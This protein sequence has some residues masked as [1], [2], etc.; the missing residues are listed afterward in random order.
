MKNE[1]DSKRCPFCK[2]SIHVEAIKCHHCGEWLEK[3][4][5]AQFEPNKQTSLRV[6]SSQSPDC[7]SATQLDAAS[8]QPPPSPFRPKRRVK[9]SSLIL[10]LVGLFFVWHI[11]AAIENGASGLKEMIV[12]ALI[13]CTTPG[14]IFILGSLALW[15]WVVK[16][17]EKCESLN[18]QS[19]PDGKDG[20]Q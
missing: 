6:E 8:I 12:G 20:T 17:E 2:E 14:S 13:Y 5:V 19:C 4:P 1:C 11:P 3:Q 9:Q 18:S 10:L 15:F 7:S 16:R